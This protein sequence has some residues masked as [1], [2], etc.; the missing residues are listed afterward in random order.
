MLPTLIGSEVPQAPHFVSAVSCVLSAV[1]GQRAVPTF[2]HR[3]FLCTH[4]LATE[5][6]PVQGEETFSN[7]QDLESCEDT[8]RAVR[9]WPSWVLA[10]LPWNFRLLVC[11]PPVP[12]FCQHCCQATDLC[13]DLWSQSSAPFQLTHQQEKPHFQFPVTLFPGINLP[14]WF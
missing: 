12:G 14:V 10:L 7:P 8:R 3:L 6:L 13:S 2:P 9:S 11:Q 5:T 1:A 4:I